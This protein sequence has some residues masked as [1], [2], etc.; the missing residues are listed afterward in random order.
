MI[1]LTDVHQVTNSKKLIQ[2]VDKSD[3]TTT[4]VDAVADAT[5]SGSIQPA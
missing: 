3:V 4:A 5:G 1:Q 2:T